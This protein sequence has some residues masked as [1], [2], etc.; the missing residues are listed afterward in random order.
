MEKRYKIKENNLKR[1][2]WLL[3][4]V[5]VL[6][7]GVKI[8]FRIFDFNLGDK[9]NLVLIV[10]QILCL[11]IPSLVYVK[12]YRLNK[13]ETMKR[14][15][16][17]MKHLPF[18]IVF[19]VAISLTAAIL[20]SL[21]YS[22]DITKSFVQTV[23]A[24]ADSSLIGILAIAIIPAFFEE[25]L[26]RGVFQNEMQNG[27]VWNVMLVSGMVFALFHISLDNFFGPLLAGIGYA[28]LVIVFN[29][30]YPAVLAHIINNLFFIFAAFI[31][32]N[33]SNATGG[34]LV[35]FLAIVFYLVIIIIT[36]KLIENVIKDNSKRFAG[37]TDSIFVEL[38][39]SVAFWLIIIVII[40]ENILSYVLS[41][42]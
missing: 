28:F 36:L 22:L 30:V 1:G 25:F 5:L 33:I 24:N 11:Y 35:D 42:H 17:K 12:V 41:L 10:L 27:K 31:G 15:H 9:K 20:N 4:A 40:G 7:T 16:F 32:K 34:T 8:V 2:L 38:F 21:L 13:K 18:I 19:S 29:S 39:K 3:F 26:F 6:L 14:R 23:S 37:R